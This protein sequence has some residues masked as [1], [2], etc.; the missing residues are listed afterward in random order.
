MV[1]L[2]P[3]AV[4]NGPPWRTCQH[5]APLEHILAADGTPVGPGQPCPHDA[6]WGTW[7]YTA[8]TLDIRRVDREVLLDPCVS[9]EAYEGVLADSDVTFYCATCKQAIVG[10]HPCPTGGDLVSAGWYLPYG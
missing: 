7:F 6:D 4:G 3:V 1:A 10:K 8:A 5:L 9:P 2:G